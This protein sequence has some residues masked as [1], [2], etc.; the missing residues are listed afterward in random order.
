MGIEL[1][2]VGCRVYNV[3]HG[4]SMVQSMDQSLVHRLWTGD[5]SCILRN[6]FWG[7][8]WT[9]SAVIRLLFV[10]D[11][12]VISSYK[13][14]NLPINA[15]YRHLN[16]IHFLIPNSYPSSL[17]TD[18]YHMSHKIWHISYCP[19]NMT[20]MIMNFQ[21]DRNHCINYVWYDFCFWML[22]KM[23]SNFF[24]DE[25]LVFR[26]FKKKIDQKIFD[27]NDRCT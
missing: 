10:E 24:L 21:I 22:R 6:I 3:D 4:P 5:Y 2:W 16:S 26:I 25:R 12:T 7:L 23:K 20:C 15:F 13:T 9:V 17:N 19:Y 11:I 8:F 14:I 27:F 18:A 1:I